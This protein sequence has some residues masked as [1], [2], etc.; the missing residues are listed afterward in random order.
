VIGGQAS[1]PLIAERS[2]DRPEASPARFA[3]RGFFFEAFETPHL[4]PD[5]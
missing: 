3:E 2:A 5:H 1:E 4:P